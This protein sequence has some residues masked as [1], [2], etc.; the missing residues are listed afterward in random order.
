M[1]LHTIKIGN[2]SS[3]ALIVLH[4]FLGMADN[5]VT[6]ARRLANFFYVLVPDMRNHGNS[7]HAE[8]FTY[9]AMVEDILELIEEENLSKL[10]LLGH[11]MG[12]KVAMLLALQN[13][14]LITALVV[15]DIAPVIYQHTLSQHDFLLKIFSSLSLSS[16]QSRKDIEQALLSQKLDQ[17][18]VQLAIKN[19]TRLPDG[20]FSWKP[21]LSVLLRSLDEINGFPSVVTTSSV[22]SLFIRGEKSSYVLPQ[23]ETIIKQYFPESQLVTIQRAGHWVHVDNAEEFYERCTDFLLSTCKKT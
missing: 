19:I 20:T 13:P 12:G 11:S 16:F 15:V 17:R 22:P 1:K 3:H 6:F 18:F 7:P 14:S 5:W 8:V 9:E 21:N 2:P 10:S 23:H 4:G